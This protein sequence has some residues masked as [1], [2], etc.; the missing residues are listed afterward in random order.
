MRDVIVVGMGPAGAAAATMLREPAS[1]LNVVG[2]QLD[3][4]ALEA[5][6]AVPTR[7]R[8]VSVQ[9]EATG[10]LATADQII[11][12]EAGDATVRNGVASIAGIE[13]TFR[14]AAEQ[15]GVQTLYDA[16]IASVTDHGRAGVHVLM[17]D[18]TLHRGRFLIDASGGRLGPFRHG[19]PA[20][21]TVYLTG[22]LPPMA[23]AGGV[24]HGGTARVHGAG[25]DR[26]L[27]NVF[28]FNDA[29][30]GATPFVNYPSMPTHGTDARS[31]HRLLRRHLRDAGI[32]P[33]GLRDAAFIST[34]HVRASSAVDGS[35]LAVGDSVR[36]VSPRT[37]AGISNGLRD[38]HDAALAV[39][40]NLAGSATREEALAGYAAV[41]S[42]R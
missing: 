22:S 9:H 29:R 20:G 26:R 1:F 36:R 3:V 33:R 18:G 11:G 35:M 25:N 19:T 37:A 28:G 10:L 13:R 24:F 8:I 17:E 42:R 16:R 39:Q 2:Q 34:P 30:E 6:A 38:A 4:L 40:L 41:A 5:R 12:R 15:V 14:Q 27:V 7:A 32:D 21:E 23:D 31:A